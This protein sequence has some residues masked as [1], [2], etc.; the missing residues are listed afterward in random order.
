MIG[1]I[2]IVM[3]VALFF[4]GVVIGNLYD[5]IIKKRKK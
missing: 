2:D 5:Y 1:I 3:W 4:A